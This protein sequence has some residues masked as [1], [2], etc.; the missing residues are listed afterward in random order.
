M[1]TSEF[2]DGIEIRSEDTGREKNLINS[3]S[4]Q[5]YFAFLYFFPNM[6]TTAFSLQVAA[7]HFLSGFF[8]H[9]QWERQ[10]TGAKSI[11]SQTHTFGELLKV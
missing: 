8:I 10:G 9:I 2:W 6:L 7:P 11:L 1:L 4:F 3:P 5:L